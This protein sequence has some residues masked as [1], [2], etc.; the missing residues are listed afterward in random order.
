MAQRG[1]RWTSTLLLPIGGL[2][3]VAAG[4]W[5][6][7]RLWKNRPGWSQ[8][9]GAIEHQGTRPEGLLLTAVQQ[10]ESTGVRS[11]SCSGASCFR[12]FEPVTKR[13][14]RRFIPWW[15]VV[16]AMGP[17]RDAGDSACGAVVASGP[18]DDC[19]ER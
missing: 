3:A 15:Q 7:W 5:T 13:G 12:R 2:L 19:P 1:F 10:E 14:W 11:M 16:G 18:G 17:G 4:A 9:A 6:A 8:L